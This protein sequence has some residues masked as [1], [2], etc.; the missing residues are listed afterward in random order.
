MHAVG[1]V[2]SAAIPVFLAGHKR[3]RTPSA[4]FFFHVYD[5]GFE[6]KQTPDRISEA[7]IR[8][9]SDIAAAKAIVGERTSILPER[10]DQMYRNAPSPTIYTSEEAKEAAIV[11]D[12]LL[13]NPDGQPEPNVAMWTVGW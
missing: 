13:L 11:S 2:G 6:G 4:R 10:L 9:E 12:I 5:W 1:H 3:T 8:L 7:V